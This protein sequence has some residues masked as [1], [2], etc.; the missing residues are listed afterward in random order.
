MKGLTGNILRTFSTQVP[1]IILSIVSGIF[2]TRLL[3]V[4][5]KGIQAIFYANMEI[6]VMLFAMGCD[7]GIIYFGSNKKISQG[8]LQ[9][10]TAYLLG[11]VLPVIAIVVLF[12]DIDFLFPKN[13]DGLF[14]KGFLIGI[15][16][17]TLVNTLLGAFLK[18]AKSFKSVNRINLFNS[19]FNVLTFV[20]MFYLNNQGIISVSIKTIFF[21]RLIILSFNTVLWLISFL[22]KIDV[23]PQFDISFKKEIYPFFKYVFPIF[24]SI[25]INFLNYRFDIWLVSYFKGNTQLGLYVLAANFAQFI[26]LYS[27]IIGSV[28]MPY[29]SEDNTG[30]R[31]KYFVTYSRINFT[32]VFLMVV[33]LAIVGDLLL[34]FLYGSEFAPSAQPFNI[35]LIGMVFTAMSQLFSI[36]L[37]SKG[38]NKV[39]LIANSVGLVATILFDVLLIPKYGIEGAAIA[40]TISYFSIFVVLLSYLLAKERISFF[41]LFILKP[42]DIKTIFQDD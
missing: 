18:S 37:F 11:I 17:L 42:K 3:G 9:A 6:M 41:E 27:R 16:G 21:V 20:V 31:K 19:I 13:Y 15:F 32:S 40:T 29:L 23:K 38:N 12:F 28:M 2:L 22:K 24:I 10:I 14:F 26:L 7:M 39:A 5:G 33:V 8:R 35:L 36:M 30:Q 1:S 25:V 4:E 34:V